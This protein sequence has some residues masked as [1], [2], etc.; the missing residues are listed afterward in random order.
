MP[1]K[2]EEEILDLD[3]ISQTNPR[4]ISSTIKTINRERRINLYHWVVHGLA[5]LII[6]TFLVMLIFQLEIPR[7]Y[8][9]LVSVVIGFYFARSLFDNNH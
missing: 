7:E 3:S 6:I 9:T 1:P 2:E 4:E 8:W 5:F